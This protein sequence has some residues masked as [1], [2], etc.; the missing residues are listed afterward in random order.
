MNTKRAKFCMWLQTKLYPKR[1]SGL[2]PKFIIFLLASL[3]PIRWYVNKKQELLRFDYMTNEL[4]FQNKRYAIRDIENLEYRQK[5]FYSECIA[6][7]KQRLE[8]ILM[9]HIIDSPRTITGILRDIGFEGVALKRPTPPSMRI[10]KEDRW[11]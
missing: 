11:T 2:R 4:I 1:A 10:L 7:S 3:H 8:K 6:I 9:L 5:G